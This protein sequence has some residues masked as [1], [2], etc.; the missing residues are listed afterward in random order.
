MELNPKDGYAFIIDG[1]TLTN[2]FDFNLEKKFRELSMKC[3]SVL[4]C[5]MSPGQKA[6]VSCFLLII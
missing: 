5:R 6:Q 3:D 4:C 1:F 2:I